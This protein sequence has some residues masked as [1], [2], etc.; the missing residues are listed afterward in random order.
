[1]RVSGRQVPFWIAITVVYG[2]AAVMTFWTL[3]QSDKAFFDDAYMFYRYALNFRHGLGW[4]WNPDGIHTYG[5][6][7]LT[8]QAVVLLAS[9]LPGKPAVALAVASTATF[10][11]TATLLARIL[12]RRSNS[13]LLAS[14]GNMLLILAL[15][16]E[17]QFAFL[18]NVTNGMD[19]M[20]GLLTSSLVALISVRLYQQQTLRSAILAG[21][22]AYLA[23]ATRPESMICALLVPLLLLASSRRP[24]CLRLCA[25]LI[26]STTL[27]VA[28]QTLGA[29][30]YFKTPVPLAF[31]LK[32]KHA[33]AGYT[34]YSGSS[35]SLS[36]AFSLAFPSLVV[37][38]LLARRAHVRL[39]LAFLL[40]TL[41]T[42]VYLSSVTQIMG[43]YAR[44]Y[45]PFLPFVIA[46]AL[47][48]LATHLSS[49]T[50]TLRLSSVRTL[51]VVLGA[52]LFS[53]ANFHTLILSASLRYIAQ[54]PAQAVPA[55]LPSSVVPLPVMDGFQSLHLVGSELAATLPAGSWIAATEVGYLGV[56]A[57]RVNILD[58]AGLNSRE[59]VTHSFSPDVIFQRRPEIL[60]F[61][62]TAYSGLCASLNR[63]PRLLQQYDVLPGAYSFGIGIRKH[64]AQHDRLLA[65]IARHWQQEYPDYRMQ[66]YLVHQD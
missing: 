28:L 34:G 8:W 1:M 18:A 42:V 48:T 46:P 6:T 40:P 59:M 13:P 9:F 43:S 4:S 22:A 20:L 3:R 37:L 53:V 24:N 60:W 35:D 32:T 65:I 29:F 25:V 30:L 23:F 2:L 12:A 26:A 66:D 49:P 33:Y 63:D 10:C 31:Y 55:L 51:V 61:P 54:H 5:M 11:A 57:P 7:S 21:V 64:S 56:A 45:I 15:P 16:L 52:S 36:I 17:M 19:T 62:H 58:L 50:S 47:V 41:V 38:A 44:Y 14:A 27:L 39:L